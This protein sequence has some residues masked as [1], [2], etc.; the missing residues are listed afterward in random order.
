MSKYAPVV[1]LTYNRL[2]EL[3]ETVSALKRNYLA[4]KTDL[5]IYSDGAKSEEDFDKVECVRDFIRGVGG[6]KKVVINESS[7]NNGLSNSVIRGVTD[8]IDKYGRVIVLE[9]DLITSPNFLDFM[10]QSLGFYEDSSEVLSISGFS[11]VLPS[12]N[13]SDDYYFG[14]RASSWGWGT[15]KSKWGKV[16]WA[17]SDYEK[18]IK[19]Y[20]YKRQFNK[21][22]S[23][24]SGMLKNYMNGR[25]DSWAIR[26]CYHQ[27]KNGMVTVF[28]SRSKVYSIGFGKSA[29]NTVGGNRFRTIID[30]SSKREFILEPFQGVD[31]ILEKEFR[32]KFS[33]KVRVLDK[34][35]RI[36]K[37]I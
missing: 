32:S 35:R 26:F 6:F 8:V 12:I 14:L 1:L 36:I 11:Y 16:D 3:K 31:P 37:K 30:E 4:S 34:V 18:F 19:N 22:G 13:S 7:V 23:D 28:P 29:T 20:S 9:D 33:I 15:W 17:V 25:I 10:N 21:G 24:L 27:F 5:H 2:D